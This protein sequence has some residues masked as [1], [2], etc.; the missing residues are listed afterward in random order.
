MS[1]QVRQALD[2]FTKQ[3][4]QLWQTQTGHAPTSEALHG[5][6][7]PCII[8]T[9]E[10][11]VEWLPYKITNQLS[12]ENVSNALD[13]CLAPDITPF[14][15][16]Q[17]A[18]DMAAIY[19]GQPLTLLQPW[20]YDDFIRLQENL[21]CHL[22]TQ[23]QHKLKP[24]LFIATI[25]SDMEIISFCNLTGNIILEKFGTRKYQVIAPN[26]SVFLQS[27]KPIIR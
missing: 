13:I 25:D 9:T 20:S 18:G 5:I 4:V 16:T 7:S 24:T 26:L 8:K 27:I 2:A 10:T 21:I 12:L 11:T 22:V 14:Y 19:D 23:R 17:Y 1:N 6:E 15:T 3:Y